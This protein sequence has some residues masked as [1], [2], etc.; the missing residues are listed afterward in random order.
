MELTIAFSLLAV[1]LT[2]IDSA[3]TESTENIGHCDVPLQVNV[4][5]AEIVTE[6]GTVET[7]TQALQTTSIRRPLPGNLTAIGISPTRECA[8]GYSRDHNG[9]CRQQFGRLTV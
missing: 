4:D 9:I 6:E 3:P 7:T 1:L 8:T 5:A 2:A